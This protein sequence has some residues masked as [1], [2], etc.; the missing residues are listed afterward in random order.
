MWGR[1]EH[2]VVLFTLEHCTHTHT[3]T[4]TRAHTHNSGQ[5]L[6]F[7]V[8]MVVYTHIYIDV[9]MVDTVYVYLMFIGPCII[10]I[11]E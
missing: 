4:H 8:F 6:G 3:H 5:M 10:L 7:E 9:F 1:A 2:K 11:V